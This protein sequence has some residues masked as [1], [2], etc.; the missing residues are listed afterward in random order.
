VT[1]IRILI[2]DDHIV[3][4][5]GLTAMLGREPDLEVV[6][7]AAE[8]EEA[9]RL[10]AN[11]SPDVILMDLRMPGMDGVTAMQHI[12]ETGTNTRFLVLTTFDTDDYI[13]QAIE[14]GAR[15]YLLKDS[16]RE[17]LFRA[18]RAVHA[19]ESLIQPAVAA[20]VLDRFAQMSRSSRANDAEA[21]SS[22]ELDVLARLGKGLANKQIAAQLSVSENTVK[23]HL[24]SIFQKLGVNDRTGAV[25]AAL[26]R[27]LIKL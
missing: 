21:L 27:G 1:K 20:R 11:L 14:A 26:Q 25:T 15:G 23:T 24:A 7:E 17:D 10:A 6:G 9:V 18:V 5:D 13:F 12:R 19:G 3:V 22:R 8:G 16:S 2:V 4:R